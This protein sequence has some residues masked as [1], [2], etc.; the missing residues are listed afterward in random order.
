[1]IIQNSFY[2]ELQ[3]VLGY[4]PQY[5]MK[6]L[7]GDFNAKLRR[8]DI[9]KLTISNESLHQ[10]SNDNGVGLVHFAT[11]KNLVVSCITCIIFSLSLAS[12]CN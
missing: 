2:E 9:L 6:I 12:P 10:D 7:V 4:F 3:Q 1:V 11:S 5:H 8:E